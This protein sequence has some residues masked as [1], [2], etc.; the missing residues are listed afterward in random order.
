LNENKLATLNLSHNDIQNIKTDCITTVTA[1]CVKNDTELRDGFLM[2]VKL[3]PFPHDLDQSVLTG[4]K[5]KSISGHCREI[6]NQG[7]NDENSWHFGKTM[8]L[9]SI[10]AD[11][12]KLTISMPRNDDTLKLNFP[13]HC[14][15]GLVFGLI[16]QCGF[17]SSIQ[18]TNNVCINPNKTYEGFNNTKN[19]S[20]ELISVEEKEFDVDYCYDSDERR[21]KSAGKFKLEHTDNNTLSNLAINITKTRDSLCGSKHIIVSCLPSVFSFS[22]K[23]GW[24]PEKRDALYIQTS[25]SA[26]GFAI[27]QMTFRAWKPGCQQYAVP[28][29]I[30]F[31]DWVNQ[32]HPLSFPQFLSSKE[33]LSM[34]FSENIIDFSIKGDF[35]E[36]FKHRLPFKCEDGIIDVNFYKSDNLNNQI[37]NEVCFPR[38]YV[39]YKKSNCPKLNISNILDSDSKDIIKTMNNTTG[40]I[41]SG[42][43]ESEIHWP[44]QYI[45]IIAGSS[46][47][48][49]L[50]LLSKIKTYMSRTQGDRSLDSPSTV[51]TSIREGTQNPTEQRNLA[52]NENSVPPG[53]APT[54]TEP[55]STHA[56]LD[57]NDLDNNDEDIAMV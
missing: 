39:S 11:S 17:N 19:C 57:S 49:L 15:Q 35:G 48:I 14:S 26:F 47:I 22:S 24:A 55:H 38:L 3:Y 56:N 53:F 21:L 50:V 7:F 43:N 18:N 6:E 20:T 40:V 41:N 52:Q 54:A 8:L 28:Y 51:P 44:W 9:L 2:R 30:E 36:R 12:Q 4:L 25:T 45:F 10:M 31:L 1:S 46:L 32:Q 37:Y 34:S 42:S 16:N 23:S 13:L 33:N 5:I 27:G 29:F